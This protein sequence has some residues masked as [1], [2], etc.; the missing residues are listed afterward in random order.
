MFKNRIYVVVLFTIIAFVFTLPIFNDFNN[1]GIQDWDQHLF[2]HAVPRASLLKYKQVPLWNP[3]NCGGIVDLAN[4]QSRTLSPTFIFILLFDVPRGIKIDIWLHLVI[5]LTGVYTLSRYYR[6]NRD[7]AI[8]ASSVFTINSMF[9]LS[10]TAGM[11]WFL[12]VAYLPWAFYNYLKSLTDIKYAFVCGIFLALMFFSGGAYPLSITGTFLGLYTFFLMINRIPGIQAGWILTLIGLICNE[13]VLSR[14][15]S[16]DGVL[17]RNMRISVWGF[18]FLFLGMGIYKLMPH[19][20][21]NPVS[22]VNSFLSFSL[23][24]IDKIKTPKN[25]LLWKN[26]AFRPG[27]LLILVIVYT[28]LIGAVKFFPSIEF[29]RQNARRIESYSGYSINSFFQSLLS[30]DQTLASIGKLSK[31]NYGIDTLKIWDKKYIKDL[32]L[33]RFFFGF[34]YNMDENGMYIGIVPLILLFIG[35]Y[36]YTDRKILLTCMVLFMWLIF[37]DRIKPDIWL[38]IH[39]LPIY[40]SMRVTQRFRIVVML[41][42]VIFVGF[43]FQAVANYIS[44]RI[45][46]KRFVQI[47]TKG[48]VIGVLI[49]LMIVNSPTWKDAFPIPPFVIPKSSEFYQIAGRGI[50]YDKTGKINEKRMIGAWGSLYPNFL[51]NIGTIGGSESAN[52]P[53]RANAF[54]S[55]N[56]KGEAFLYKTEGK[57]KFSQWSPNRFQFEYDINKPGYLVVNQNFYPGWKIKGSKQTTEPI[58]GLLAVK[59]TPE[60]KNVEMY[61]L[62]MSFLAGCLTTAITVLL[63]LFFLLRG[64]SN[65][66]YNEN[67]NRCS[68]IAFHI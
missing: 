38:L 64:R 2:Y 24:I 7:A 10:L 17:T 54:N 22:W 58:D 50:P 39:E 40:D 66:R 3:Y 41:C 26:E 29:M 42:A 62:P 18:S 57:V 68:S 37:G 49:D 23:H 43:G 27:F 34:S 32:Q 53:R 60:E 67:L 1:W 56:Y 59:I 4:P 65:I 8:I 30:R 20:S 15:F 52:V 13:W 63:G 5:A 6:L 35:I 19:I 31:M 48:I 47:I 33:K 16:P 45:K 28:L 61:Y 36:R 25:L 44:E 11:T 46:N 51:S 14:L 55:N 12:S 9:A 21:F